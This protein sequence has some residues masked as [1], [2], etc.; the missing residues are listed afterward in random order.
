M[1]QYI[2]DVGAHCVGAVKELE[3][4]RWELTR[5]LW[6]DTGFEVECVDLNGQDQSVFFPETKWAGEGDGPWE[7]PNQGLEDWDE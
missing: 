2:E 7:V 1:L 5:V 4:S 6:V 3:A